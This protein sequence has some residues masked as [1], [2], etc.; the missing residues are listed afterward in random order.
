MRTVVMFS[1]YDCKCLALVYVREEFHKLLSGIPFR[2]EDREADGLGL[3]NSAGSANERAICG[4]NMIEGF[5]FL[6]SVVLKCGENEKVGGGKGG[7]GV[8]TLVL[9]AFSLF[10]HSDSGKSGVCGVSCEV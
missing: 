7:R 1:C 5:E 9:P 10:C 3:A 4:F 8:K 6:P 2:W